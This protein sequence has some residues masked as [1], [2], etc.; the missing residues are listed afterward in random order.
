M[1]NNANVNSLSSRFHDPNESLDDIINSDLGNLGAVWILNALNC[2]Q[3][4][5]DKEN[6]E[7]PSKNLTGD[8]NKF[9]NHE[10]QV[11]LK[12]EVTVPQATQKVVNGGKCS[13]VQSING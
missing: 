13:V 2:L 4:I 9:A 11:N 10:K 6:P 3:E 1:C 7:I 12:N 8:D 5:L